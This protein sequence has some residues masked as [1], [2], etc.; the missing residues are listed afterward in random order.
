MGL[1]GGSCGGAKAKRGPGRVG[2]RESGPGAG[3]PGGEASGARQR[4][5][6]P[7]FRPQMSTSTCRACSPPWRPRHPRIRRSFRPRPPLH[8]HLPQPRPQPLPQPQ[9][10]PQQPPRKGED[11]RVTTAPCP[12]P[13]MPAPRPRLSG[14]PTACRAVEGLYFHPKCRVSQ[15]AAGGAGRG[16]EGAALSLPCVSSSLVWLFTGPEGAGS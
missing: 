7:S 10:R 13:T 14:L 9:A 11:P 5:L 3:P 1:L 8:L 16:P 4:G 6:L 2:K 12:D 15:L